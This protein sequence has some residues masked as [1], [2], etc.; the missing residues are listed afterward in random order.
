M[1]TSCTSTGYTPGRLMKIVGRVP[2]PGRPKTID[3][4]PCRSG[5]SDATLMWFGS[6]KV[7]PRFRF[8]MTSSNPLRD[9]VDWWMRIAIAALGCAASVGL[10]MCNFIVKVWRSG[11]HVSW[12]TRL[13][14]TG[15]G[16]G[17]GTDVVVSCAWAP[18]ALAPTNPPK[19]VTVAASTSPTRCAKDKR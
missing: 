5:W 4:S 10:S 3:T 7:P 9:V 14:P 17:L 13:R 16:G 19:T 2:E 12:L 11:T 6:Y 8:A 15:S 18:E 1:F